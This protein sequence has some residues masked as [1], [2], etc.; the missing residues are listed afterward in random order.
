MK[1]CL[2]C[3]TRYYYYVSLQSGLNSC[4][5]AASLVESAVVRPRLVG[6]GDLL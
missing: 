1:E 4:Q 3:G 5:V 6:D 2:A